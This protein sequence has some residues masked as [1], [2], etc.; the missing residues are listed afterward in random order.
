MSCIFSLQ[1]PH[2]VKPKI[3][4]GADKRTKSQVWFGEPGLSDQYY[5]T[6]TDS[7]FKP[8]SVPY[9]NHGANIDKRTAVPLDYY[10]KFMAFIYAKIILQNACIA[11]LLLNNS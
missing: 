9:T 6:T 4:S 11:H 2:T 1:P 7:T 5:E 10:G 3:E 8:V